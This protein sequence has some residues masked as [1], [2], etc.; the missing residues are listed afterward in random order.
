M[1]RCYGAN[2]AT[3]VRR[4]YSAMLSIDASMR[5]CEMDK[6]NKKVSNG[7]ARRMTCASA[8]TSCHVQSSNLHSAH[9]H[10]TGSSLRHTHTH[11]PQT[12]VAPDDRM[13]STEARIQLQ[14]TIQRTI[15]RTIQN[16]RSAPSSHPLHPI[17]S[18]TRDP[19]RSTVQGTSL[20]RPT[21]LESIS[22][23]PGSSSHPSRRPLQSCNQLAI[24]QGTRMQ[25][26]GQ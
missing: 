10:R 1:V 9:T 19:A 16:A 17:S 13:K 26:H 25:H 2:S 4:C 12:P 11:R 18:S 21:S 15:Q 8:S 24:P 6:K 3:T 5:R 7:L 22:I 14:S 20:P 23:S